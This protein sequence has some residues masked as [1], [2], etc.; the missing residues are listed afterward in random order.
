MERTTRQTNPNN[1]KLII[2]LKGW[3]DGAR[4]RGWADGVRTRGWA[5]GARTQRW[6]DGMRAKKRWA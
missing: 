5:D 3:A 1:L 6:A 4:T 2:S